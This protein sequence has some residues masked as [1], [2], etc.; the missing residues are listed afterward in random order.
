M[1]QEQSDDQRGWKL[2]KCLSLFGGQNNTKGAG[3]FGTNPLLHK[4]TVCALCG[5]S[6]GKNSGSK[7]SYQVINCDRSLQQFL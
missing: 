6:Y 3:R 1:R 4:K 7:L 5:L 2:D